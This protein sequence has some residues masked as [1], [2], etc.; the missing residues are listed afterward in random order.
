M[1]CNLKGV[2]LCSSCIGRQLQARSKVWK[3][4][5]GGGG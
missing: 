5:A 4:W 2:L 1:L 3:Q